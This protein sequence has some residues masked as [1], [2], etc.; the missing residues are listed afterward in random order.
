MTQPLGR[1]DLGSQ[2]RSD[3]AA[4]NCGLGYPLCQ[5][6]GSTSANRLFFRPDIPGLDLAV[7]LDLSGLFIS[8]T[9]QL[10][11]HSLVCVTVSNF[12]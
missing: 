4:G 3:R 12:A 7:F 9:V 10:G 8:I 1:S 6:Y 11:A 2:A 5:I